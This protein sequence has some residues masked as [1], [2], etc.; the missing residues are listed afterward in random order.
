MATMAE[1]RA[2]VQH[3]YDTA[4]LRP[5]PEFPP[6]PDRFLEPEQFADILA[7]V[8]L[9]HSAKVLHP[10]VLRLMRGEY[11]W[12]QLQ[13]WAK[14]GFHDKIQTIRND[15]MILAT[16]AT[17]EEMKQQARVVA[18][19]AG[20]DSSGYESHPELWLRFGEGLGLTREEILHSEPTPLTE[21]ILE[22]ER[23][24]ALSQRIG[25]LPTNLRLGER[26]SSIVFPM[27][28]WALVEKYGVPRE[29]TV[30]FQAHEEADEDH[31][32]IGREIIIRRATTLEM[33]R[34]MWLHQKCSQAKQWL[35][36]DAYLQAVMAVEPA[37]V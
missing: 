5:M 31:S 32:Q 15:A 2:R 36:Y 30:W 16:A 26:V 13:A 25:G 1:L 33:Q 18:S 22:A 29:A 11:T 17:L 23:C 10:F 21:V 8:V 4:P 37:A 9:E 19:E 34:E 27:W 28:G 6:P 24:R 20:V 35:S 7:D 3:I 12:R 14:E